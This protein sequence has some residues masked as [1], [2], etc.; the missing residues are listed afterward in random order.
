MYM[1][2]SP[3]QSWLMRM[4]SGGWAVPSFLGSQELVVRSD[5]CLSAQRRL[6]SPS[7]K[8]AHYGE[9]GIGFVRGSQ[10]WGRSPKWLF[11][12]IND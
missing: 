12:P 8:D 9:C 11:T 1:M 10:N 5:D 2:V 6:E 7:L 4:E 3:G